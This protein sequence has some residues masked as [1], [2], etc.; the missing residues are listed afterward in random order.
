MLRPSDNVAL[1]MAPPWEPPEKE[2]EEEEEDPD[3]WC[4]AL[5]D[6]GGFENMG[7][8]T[9]PEVAKL[10]HSDD[11]ELGKVDYG[12]WP[13]GAFSYTTPAQAGHCRAHGRA[14]HAFHHWQ[15]C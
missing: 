5:L 7:P 11:V 3:A 6:D 12:A 14:E 9:D 15:A 2:E 4:R 10:Y 13:G 1:G 8:Y